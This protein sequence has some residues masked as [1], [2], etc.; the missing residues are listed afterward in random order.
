ML[1]YNK[2]PIS[3]QGATMDLTVLLLADY[4]NVAERGKL[5]VMG[6]FSMLYSETFPTRHPEMHLIVKLSAS[7]A[8]Y[9]TTRKLI[10]KLLNEDATQEIVNW[11]RDIQVPHGTGERVEINQILR[12]TQLVF[13]TPGRYQFSVM[14]DND[15]KGV[16]PLLI[17]QKDPSGS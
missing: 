5:N 1:H 13:P 16:L 3:K 14:V 15:E 9:D 10:I 4:A 12:L 7:P 2:R 6:I 8:E 11:S 17:L